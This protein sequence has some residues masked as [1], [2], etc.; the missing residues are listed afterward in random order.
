MHILRV[1]L[2]VTWIVK[3][4]LQIL[5]FWIW[6]K[7]HHPHLSSP[8]PIEIPDST[9]VAYLISIISFDGLP[10]FCSVCIHCLS[11][12]ICCWC[13]VSSLHYISIYY[14][15]TEKTGTLRKKLSKDAYRLYSTYQQNHFS[16]NL[17]WLSMY[18]S[19]CVPT[20]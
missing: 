17:L 19:I 3:T 12:F 9:F 11:S 1:C 2:T 20:P 10:L 4:N 13:K 14:F 5:S 18:C 6:V 15:T 16:I 7:I 8:V